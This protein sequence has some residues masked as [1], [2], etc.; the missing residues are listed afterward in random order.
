MLTADIH[1]IKKSVLLDIALVLN[2]LYKWEYFCLNGLTSCLYG[3]ELARLGGL[4]HLGEILPS[5]RNS[6]KNRMCSYDRWARLPRWDRTWLCRDPTEIDE[7]FPY[8][9]A[10]VGP[11]DSLARWDTFL[12]S[13]VF[14]QYQLNNIKTFVL[15]EW[16]YLLLYFVFHGFKSLFIVKMLQK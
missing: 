7:N 1:K 10:Q 13:F 12:I 2:V 8:E 11:W 5:L 6:F 14:F 15:H 4:A 9:H 16:L 3:G